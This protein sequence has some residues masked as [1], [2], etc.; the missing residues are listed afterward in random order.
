[1][2]SEL[3][4]AL[5]SGMTAPLLVVYLNAVRGIELGSATLAAAVGPLASLFGNPLGGVLADRF[6]GRR[7]V[8]A[9]LTL[10]AASTASL[11]VMHSMAGILTVIGLMG[12]GISIALPSQDSLLASIIPTHR[13]PAAFALRYLSLNLGLGVGG[14]LSVVAVDI[15]HPESFTLAYA[16][17]GMTFFIAM[18]AMVS[19]QV[20]KV[21]P[22]RSIRIALRRIVPR[23][24]ALWV[25][26]GLGSALTLIGFSQ[27]KIATYGITG[28]GPRLLGLAYLAN[29]ITVVLVQIPTLQLLRGWR[30]NRILAAVSVLWATAWLLVWAAG[31]LWVGCLVVAAAIIAIGECMM[32]VSLPTI[33]NDIA[34]DDA[35]G[36]YNASFLMSRT[37]GNLC[38]PVISGALFTAGIG[39]DLALALAAMACL[40][41]IPCLG[42]S[43]LMPA[44]VNRSRPAHAR[45]TAL[46]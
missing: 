37:L 25:I 2:G 15:D 39:Q 1:M 30:R 16:A 38:V 34:P 9:G 33:V 10:A 20:R 35:R 36:R 6:G 27:F 45:R 12:A 31:A 32:S 29:T 41:A 19:P 17:D 5:G 11:G 42:L 8:M 24:R 18:L 23:D 26:C 7:I 40:I 3:A 4:S 43:R 13:R 44:M 21:I 14:L 46:P 22:I 28:A